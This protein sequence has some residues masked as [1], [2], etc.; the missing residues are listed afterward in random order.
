ME[1]GKV[2]G[3]DYKG[4]VVGTSFTGKKVWIVAG[5]GIINA[6]KVEINADTVEKYNLINDGATS[7]DGSFVK[8]SIWGAAAAINSANAKAQVLVEIIFKDGKKALIQCNKK[9]YQL[10]QVACYK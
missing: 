5:F 1:S 9:L 7:A 2:V 4:Q 10:I 8:A 3:G 6:K